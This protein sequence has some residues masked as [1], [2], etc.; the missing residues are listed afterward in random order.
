MKYLYHCIYLNGGG[1]EINGGIFELKETPK[2]IIF[3]QKIKS[4]FNC[5]YET[6]KAKKETESEVDGYK[7]YTGY[8]DVIKTKSSKEYI[9]Y[10][11]Q[12]GTPH[13]LTKITEQE[14]ERYKIKNWHENN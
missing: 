13:I 2:T 12:C 4:F 1:A 8:G 5:N 10:P 14:L 3:K 9:A 11:Q 7:V 6:I